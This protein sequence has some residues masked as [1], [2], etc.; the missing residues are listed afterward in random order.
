MKAREA[1][2]R[3]T[4]G[5]GRRASLLGGPFRCRRKL[6]I[7]SILM[8]RGCGEREWIGWEA[9]LEGGMGRI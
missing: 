4:G 5:A 6:E 7:Y 8:V 9:E 1:V 3:C 2:A